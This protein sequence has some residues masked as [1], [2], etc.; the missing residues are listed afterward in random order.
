MEIINLKTFKMIS[1][2]INENNSV[3]DIGCR[4]GGLKYFLDK[5]NIK[6][7]YLGIDLFLKIKDVYENVKN[8]V[9]KT[10]I[11][12]FKTNKKFDIIVLSHVLEHVKSPYLA[13]KK[14]KNFLKEGGKIL[15]VVPNIYTFKFLAVIPFNLKNYPRGNNTHLQEFTKMEITNLC[16]VLGLNIEHYE[17]RGFEIPLIKLPGCI[18]RFLSR[19]FPWMAEELFFVLKK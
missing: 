14:G 4:D 11:E 15:L 13:L 8:K 18:Q 1:K 6:I 7:D 12:E 10:G 17:T 3:L 16:K 5:N 2:F 19:I 9:I